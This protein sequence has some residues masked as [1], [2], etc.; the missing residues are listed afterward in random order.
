MA[1]SDG[2]KDQRRPDPKALLELAA[3]EKRG[4][5]KVFLGMAPGVGK[6]YAML[7]AAHAQKVEG[8]D[9]VVGVIET[10]G[11]SETAVLL[12]G[13]EVL[14][15]KPVTYQ[16]HVLMEFD[17]EAAL[18]RRPGLL[19]VDEFAHTNAPGGLHTKRFRDVEELLWSGIDVWTTLNI[20]HLESLTDV[21]ERIT[22]VTVRE[23]VP[24]KVL[25]KA[26]EIVVVDL[27]PADLIQRLR[28]GKVYLP[29]NARRAIDQFFKPANLTALRELALRH[30]ADRVDVQ[31]LEQ[32]RQQGIEGPWPTAERL[33][34]CVGG[35][36]LS[37]TVVRTGA[38]LAAGLKSEWVAVHLKAASADGLERNV[39]RRID[40]SLR[41]A[42]R[43]GGKP[44]R[45]TATDLVAEVLGYAKRNNITQIVIGRSSAGLWSRLR[46]RTLPEQILAAARGFAVTVVTPA[47]E[48]TETVAWR[49]PVPHVALS[50]TGAAAGAVAL[51]VAAGHWLEKHVALPNLSMI[52]LLAVMSCA[53]SFGVW[54]ALIASALSFLAYNF[55]F[56]DPRYTFTVAE[57]HE[58]FALIIFLAV[59]VVTGWMAGRLKEQSQAIAER[60]VATQSLYEFSR[61]LAGAATLDHVLWLLANQL[62][63][64]A[65]GTSIILMKRGD[66]LRIEGGWPPE[67]TLST[68][69][70][71]AARWAFEHKEP[72]GRGTATMP[73]ARFQFRNMESTK[74]P[75][76]VVGVA[77]DEDEAEPS[78]SSEAVQHA[79]IDQAALAVERTMLVEEAAQAEKARE[80]D[81]LRAELL[82]SLSH[83][84]RTPLSSIIGSVTSLRSFGDK[85][86]A[87]DRADLLATIDE[88]A[89]R[90]SRFVSNLLDM[91]RLES[92]AVKLRSDPVAVAEVIRDTCARA[93]RTLPKLK[94]E[95]RLADALPNVPG[96]ATLLGQVLFNLL[97][98]AQKYSDAGSRTE[99]SAARS[100]GSVRIAV[101]DEGIGI[102]KDALEKVF[103][104]FY[105]VEGSDGR[106]A[107]TGLGLSICAAVIKAMNGTIRAESPVRHGKGTRIIIEL[108]TTD[109]GAT[110]R[111]SATEARQA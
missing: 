37:E 98:N 53:L 32:L 54:S 55:F 33:L 88:E 38:R 34:V 13:L 52:F 19:L 99:V 40:K 49:W 48:K 101:T 107:G 75:I 57:P 92:G 77:P 74:G 6:T 86:P 21:V 24:D 47:A 111:T 43:L 61:T 93:S 18:A 103:E 22:G 80:N 60:A 42:E 35:S 72:A 7:S 105:R 79:L 31:M 67:D 36:E 17:L 82:S 59:A 108:P 85:M 2:D 109:A 68:S 4:R 65:K 27:T 9:V 46:R 81:K 45:L 41:L 11:R 78:N 100:G 66:E 12:D 1:S 23:T 58:L 39:K 106:V 70:W 51:A 96:D 71:A 89:G 69:D 90:L 26:D 62:A 110:L 30:T 76:G 102:P 15:R 104:K 94:T 25:L 83:D 97:D 44:V 28:E 8:R 29:E 95:L 64:L 16:G 63:A 14:P 73:T 3:N 5:L 56:I 10:H 91:T 87:S 50:G 84:L 20:Q